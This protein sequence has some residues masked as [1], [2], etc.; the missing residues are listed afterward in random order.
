MSP[1]NVASRLDP[2]E[3]TNS[4]LPLNCDGCCHTVQPCAAYKLARRRTPY[5]GLHDN[6]SDTGCPSERRPPW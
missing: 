3:Q 4:N 2:N 5:S 6:L 1:G